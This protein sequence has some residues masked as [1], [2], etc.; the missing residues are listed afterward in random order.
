M[1]R[2]SWRSMGAGLAVAATLAACGDDEGPS[3]SCERDTGESEISGN[4][5]ATYFALLTGNAS[6][7]VLAYE[8]DAGTQTLANP[9]LPFST[10]VP[11][12]TARARIQAGGS[13]GT[14][15]FTIGYQ[16]SDETG[17]I[18][19]TTLTCP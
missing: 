6:L 17:P 13:P 16:L 14:G 12:E 18:E 11:L 15:S 4:V 10:T 1:G 8:T 3:Q 5:T 9:V 2:L 19:E 7:S